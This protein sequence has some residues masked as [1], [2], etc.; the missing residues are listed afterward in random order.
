MSKPTTYYEPFAKWDWK[1]FD[2]TI[3]HDPEEFVKKHADHMFFIGTDSQH[4]KTRKG[5]V[6][7][8]TSAIIAY[9]MGTGGVS[10]I[11]T[12]KTKPLSSLRQRLL[13]ETMRS[14][15]CAWFLDQQLSSNNSI[16]ICKPQ[17]HLDVNP[18]KKHKSSQYLQELVGLV[19]GQGFEAVC[20]PNAWA[21]S[22]LAD[23]KC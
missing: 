23:R 7:Y 10:I 14:V 21:A 5:R 16:T 2:G 6:C 12:D 22:K 3:K 8:F 11:H 18:D 13:I 17:I 15:E 19:V 4:R 20:K 1:S 9:K